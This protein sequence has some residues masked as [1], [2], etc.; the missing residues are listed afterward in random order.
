[1]SRKICVVTGTRAEYGLLRWVMQGIKDEPGL[2][3]QVIATGMHLSPEFGLTYRAIEQDG[4]RIYR[5]VEMLMSSDTAVGIAKSM[6]L[7]MIGFADAFA[8]LQPDLIVVLGDRFE[9]FSAVSAAL[10]ACIPVAHLHGGETT[11][12]AFDEALRHSITKMSH[13]HFVAAEPY[14]QRVVQLGEHPARV[15]LVGGLG[16]DSIKRLKLLSRPALEASLG[17]ALG[18][19]NLLITFHPVTLESATASDQMQE[20]LD[21]LSVLD[22]TRL[23]F[24]LPNADNDGR[25]LIGMIEQFVAAHPNAC[26]YPSLGQLRY[27]SCMSLVDGVVGNSSSGLLEA[28]SF[29][30]GT[31]NIGDRQQGRLKAGSIIDCEPKCASI[32]VAIKRLYSKEFQQSLDRIVNPYG[33]G[34]ASSRVVE[35][36]KSASLDGIV[37][38]SFYD[39]FLTPMTMKSDK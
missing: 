2:M 21:A 32:T 17:I 37:R 35:I 27:L 30:K 10:V 24:T 13:L 28:P 14:R 15:F 1:M 39:L 25:M 3:L 5:K 38:K 22:D 26:A 8:Q 11:E 19:K 16:I 18:K 29:R 6:G 4:F 33:E 23:I 36:L 31:V 9:I 12:G 20:L 34:G 7:G